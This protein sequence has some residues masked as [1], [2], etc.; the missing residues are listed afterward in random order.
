MGYGLGPASASAFNVPAKKRV[1]SIMGDG[2]F[3][4][5]GLST[6]IGNAVYNK[7]DGVTVI[8]DNFY[9]AATGGQDI[10]S[11]RGKNQVAL[12]QQFDRQGGARRRREMGAP[13]RPHLRR[14]EDARH[15]EGG[16][17]DRREG[18]EGHRRVVGV[19]AE[20]A[21][22]ARSRWRRRRSP[23]ASAW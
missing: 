12:D 22:A 4:H 8:V 6:S 3:W 11:S 7:H 19:H 20:Q 9:S 1:I 23:T 17:D 15:A 14:D 21:S 10:L 2:G 18:A 5:N 16:A 13:D